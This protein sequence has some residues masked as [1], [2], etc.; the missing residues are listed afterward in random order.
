MPADR[1]AIDLAHER[2]AAVQQVRV[3]KVPRAP[4]RVG[5]FDETQLQSLHRFWVTQ[6]DQIELLEEEI[7]E[8]G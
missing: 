6:T 8:L 7:E 1:D 4:K 5:R 3:H 2:V